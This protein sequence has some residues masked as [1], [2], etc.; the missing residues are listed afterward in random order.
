MLNLTKKILLAFLASIIV[1]IGV[2][3]LAWRI[4]PNDKKHK[5]DKS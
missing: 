2:L 1:S 3:L 4:I 5:D